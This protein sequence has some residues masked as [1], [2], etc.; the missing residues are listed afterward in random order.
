[1]NVTPLQLKGLVSLQPAL[2]L[3]KGNQNLQGSGSSTHAKFIGVGTMSIALPH[4]VLPNLDKGKLICSSQTLQ[5]CLSPW[6]W[7]W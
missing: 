3:T 6:Q 7:M 1:M 2:M 5:L 4:S